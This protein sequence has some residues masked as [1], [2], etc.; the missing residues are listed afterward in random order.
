MAEPSGAEV[1]KTSAYL[2]GDELSTDSGPLLSVFALQEIMMKV[3]QAQSDYV[4]AARDV[5]MSVP[6]VTKI[7]DGIKA[8]SETKLYEI[9]KKP[10]TSYRHVVMQSKDKFLRIDTY[11][12][13]MSE[14][15]DATDEEKPE[16]FYQTIIKK[17]R[18]L[19]K[20]GSFILHDIPT[21]DH[22]GLEVADAEILGVDFKNI[23]P[24]LT[25]E[26][27]AMMQN[28]L[29]GA[30]IENGNVATRDVDIYQGACS[31]PVY[32]IYNR[33]QAYIAGVQGDDLRRAIE[34]LTRLG[35]RK[36]ITFSQE[37]LTDFRR[38]DTIWILA[39][40]L[41]INPMVIWDVPRSGIA[42]LIMNIA[43][44]APTGEYISPNP[45]ISAI[46]LTQRITTTGPFAILTGATPTAQQLND[47]R[48]IYLALMFPGQIILDIKVDASERMDPTVRMVAGVVGHL[49]FTA[50]RNFTNITQHMARQLDI[51]LQDFLLYM[52][53]ARVP[54]N[55]GPTG[56]PLDFQ[57]GRNRY[58]CNVFRANFQTGTGYNGWAVADVEVREQGAYDHVQRFLRYCN[59]DS[60]ELINPTTFGIGMQYH[61]YNQMTL[62]LVAA[63]KDAEAAY[64]RQM[65]PFHMVRFGR[66][67]QIINEDLHSAFSLPDDQ[68]Q[69]LLPNMLQGI[70]D[71]FDPIVL[72]I[73]WISIWFAFNRCFEPT[74]RNELLEVA[75]L[76]E[77]VYASELSV[78]KVDMQ[79]MALLQ[80]RAP[81]TLIKARPTHFWK[82]VLD[83]SPEP[84]KELMDLSHA[85]HFI[86]LRDM[87]RWMNLP[88]L[89][90]SLKLV[91]ERE[92][93]AVAADMEELMLVDQVYMHRDALPEP[94]LD[95]IERFR[96]E[97]YYYTNMLD[98]PPHIHRVVQYTYEI[99]RLQANMGQFRSALR[100]IM[101]DGDWVRFG[102]VLRTV[103]VKFYDARPPEEILHK[104]PFDYTT[105]D[106]GGLAYATIKY[107]TEAVAY[108]LIYNVEFSNMPDSLVLINPTYTMTKV[109]L[110]KRV[111][112]K[113][114]VG[115]VFTLLNKRFIAYKGKMRIM[116]ITQALKMGTKL[117]VP[118][119]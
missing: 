101:D 45:R 83:V 17:V 103:R 67:N 62:M 27:R 86:N 66:I 117:A 65:L 80:R 9:V 42:N 35:R 49:M 76:I 111:V 85:H 4:A 53:T 54:V 119:Q 105:N 87:M 89:Q 114:T 18:H 108:Y 71:G 115:Q 16:L 23:L 15:G 34:W 109:F 112:E 100:R 97:G 29:D 58:D 11:Y 14:V 21:H 93:W 90:D 104:L 3:R 96:Q 102:G 113:V 64:L 88:A 24:M 61:V 78:M 20:E 28:L 8:L 43:T 79:H 95:D 75:P 6:D 69:A 2:K 5:D 70:H 74:K 91:L 13:R 39:L 48:K 30:V 26:H 12:E 72:D 84:V 19:C 56:E 92:A 10:P 98:A 46:T 7:V 99:A 63:G 25:A 94:R 31:E 52:H 68:F 41:P 110:N 116:D 40:Q 82:A 51:A 60:R 57:I 55:Y 59:I 37:Y 38:G 107:A 106:K 1:P 22:R 81:D 118:T 77:S 32:R 33:L 50:G 36:R 47:V 44:C 73:S